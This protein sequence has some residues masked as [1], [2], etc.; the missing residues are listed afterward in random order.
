MIEPKALLFGAA[1]AA[2][3]YSIWRNDERRL[4]RDFA[5]AHP[6]AGPLEPCRIRF[7]LGEAQ[8][9]CLVG[10]DGAGLYLTSSE[11]ARARSRWSIHWRHYYVLRTPLFIPWEQLEYAQARFPLKQSVRFAVPVNKAVFFMPRAAAERLLQRA[12]RSPVQFQ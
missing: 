4:K 3:I 8:T 9:D 7:P 10:A 5:A 2:W 12:G 1:F 11:E 6:F